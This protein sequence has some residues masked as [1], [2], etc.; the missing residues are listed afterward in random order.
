[1]KSGGTVVKNVAG[2]DLGQAG[3]RLAR[4][5]GRDRGRHVQAGCRC[6]TRRPRCG[7]RL[8]RRG[9][10]G[11]RRA[12]RCA[13]SQ[14]EPMAFDVRVAAARPDGAARDA[15]RPLRVE[16]A[17]HGG[18]SSTALA[19]LVPR[20]SRA[21]RARASR[22]TSGA[23]RWTL[24]WQGTRDGRAC[25]AG[26]PAALAAVLAAVGCDVVRRRRC[27]ALRVRRP[28]GASARGLLRLDGDV[29]RR[30]PPRDC[31]GSAQS[32]PLGHVVVLRGSRALKGA[33]GRV[34][35]RRAVVAP[36]AALK[37]AFDPAGILNAGRG[38][39]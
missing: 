32:P 15:A 35:R 13:S 34:G 18:A 30:R 12:R 1:M 37:R 17:A 2:Y 10:D 29:G 31:R 21:A 19:A 33:G 11:R 14:L 38:P 4:Q 39:L 9:G 26:L 3:Q 6:R 7:C 25:S 23:S 16:P 27:A 28:R 24:P 5:P 8:R 20:R 22:R 36:L